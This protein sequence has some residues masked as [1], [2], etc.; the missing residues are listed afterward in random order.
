MEILIS[1]KA[2]LFCSF[3]VSMKMKAPSVKKDASLKILEIYD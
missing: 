3:I 2:S 1:K